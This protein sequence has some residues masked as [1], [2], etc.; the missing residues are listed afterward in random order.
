MLFCNTFYTQVYG[1]S[2]QSGVGVCAP[3]LT[4]GVHVRRERPQRS[5]LVLLDG[6]RRI[7]LGDVIVR[8]HR[9]QDVGYIRL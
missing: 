7:E 6:F 9:D 4:D 1:R 8:I 3:T 5:A 2:V